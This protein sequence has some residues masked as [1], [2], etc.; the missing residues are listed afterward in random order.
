[1]EDL[2]KLLAEFGKHCQ[3]TTITFHYSVGIT[4]EVH[5]D[6]SFQNFVEWL[7]DREQTTNTKGGT[8]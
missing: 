5:P 4:S 8:K 6:V 3:E 1:M 2:I 7:A